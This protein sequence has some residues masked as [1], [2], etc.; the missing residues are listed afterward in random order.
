MEGSVSGLTPVG[1][2]I[3]MQC[4][5]FFPI[6]PPRAQSVGS[7]SSLFFCRRN[8]THAHSPRRAHTVER[9]GLVVAVEERRRLLPH[10]VVA[11]VAQPSQPEKA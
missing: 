4:N 9:N 6:S 2:E 5:A 11:V 8:H 1:R 3:E 7:E 10:G